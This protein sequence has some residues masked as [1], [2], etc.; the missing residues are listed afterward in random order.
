[1]STD[2]ISSKQY[3]VWARGLG[4]ISG[5][6]IILQEKSAERYLT[7]ES[8]HRERLLQDLIEL[9]EHNPQ[10]ALDFVKRHGL[11]W[12]GPEHLGSGQCRESLTYWRAV[13]WDLRILIGL[14]IRLDDAQSMRKYLRT[15]RDG[16]IFRAAIP[17]NDQTCLEYASIELSRGIT[18]GL[19]GCSW[20]LTAA[21]TLKRDGTKVGGPADFLFGDDPPHLVAAAYAQ[22][23]SLIVNKIPFSECEGC[24]KLFTPKHGSQKYCSKQCSDRVRK[25]RQRAKG[26]R[27]T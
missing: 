17:D 3:P 9:S 12:H 25:V 4:H 13:A 15:L 2:P 5:D 23:A 8:Q 21:C 24:G 7:D 20:T 11:L 14:Y 6:E 22:L 1:M 26:A 10:G 19:E 18:K 16:G 27:D